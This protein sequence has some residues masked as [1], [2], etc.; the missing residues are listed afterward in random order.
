MSSGMSEDGSRRS[1]SVGV[2]VPLELS[3]L[4]VHVA[5]LTKY[6]SGTKVS[7]HLRVLI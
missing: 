2:Y 3:L 4:E 6:T 1:S 5:P 7:T